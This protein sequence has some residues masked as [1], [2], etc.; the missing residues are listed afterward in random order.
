[1]KYSKLKRQLDQIE[2]NS[3]KSQFDDALYL[4]LAKEVVTFLKDT[5]QINEELFGSPSISGISEEDALM[6]EGQWVLRLKEMPFSS[7]LKERIFDN[8]KAREFDYVTL[9]WLCF[10]SELEELS[11]QTLDEKIAEIEAWFELNT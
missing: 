11:N 7:Q 9:N 3:Q 4:C 10:E 6:T 5:R 1:M 2:S 8:Y